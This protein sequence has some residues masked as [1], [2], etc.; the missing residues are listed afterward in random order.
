MSAGSTQTAVTVIG[1]RVP[2]A[3]A[4]DIRRAAEAEDR[5]VSYFI[6]RALRNEVQRVGIDHQPEGPA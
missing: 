6:R 1:S 3:F 4:E 5:S 2:V